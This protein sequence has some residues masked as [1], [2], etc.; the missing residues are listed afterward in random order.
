MG[1]PVQRAPLGAAEASF[2]AARGFPS[3]RRPFDPRHV[4][5][6]MDGAF[7]LP[8]VQDTTGGGGHRTVLSQATQ[9]NPLTTVAFT[10]DIPSL[11]TAGNGAAVWD[12][13][14][15]TFAGMRVT[16][17]GSALKWTDKGTY[18]GWFKA[19]SVDGSVRMFFSQWPE[20]ASAN[21]RLQV[22]LTSGDNTRLNFQGSWTGLSTDDPTFVNPDNRFKFNGSS[23]YDFTEWHYLEFRFDVA[24]ANYET[25][26][27]NHSYRLR[28]TADGVWD[29]GTGYSAPHDAPEPGPQWGSPPDGPV[30]GAL[31]ESTTPF[32]VGSTDLSTGSWRGQI[33]P[34]YVANETNG[35]IPDYVRTRIRN[36]RAPGA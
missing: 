10:G 21:N 5:Q 8:G 31:F 9:S 7:W 19:N 6:L 16:T 25:G 2:G 33:G 1:W 28:F 24:E 29:E 30:R 15:A 20:G 18:A 34:V 26:G 13:S 23:I 4:P 17:P 12:Y 14:V 27:F 11:T 22:G 3:A 35:R 32:A 36:Y